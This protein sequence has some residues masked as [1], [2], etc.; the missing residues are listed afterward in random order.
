V[1]VIHLPTNRDGFNN[2]VFPTQL[3]PASTINTI[4]V[5]LTSVQLP[6]ISSIPTLSVAAANLFHLEVHP[7]SSI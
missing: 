1:P 2:A 7:L 5:G 4:C 6:P 3:P